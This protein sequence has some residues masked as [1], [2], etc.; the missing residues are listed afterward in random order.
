[1]AAQV[2]TAVAIRAS[3]TISRLAAS[4]SLR[5]AMNSPRSGPI[6]AR[7]RTIRVGVG[8]R[9]SL[10][11]ELTPVSLWH[12]ARRR[13]CAAS[14]TTARPHLHR[15]SRT[16]NNRH[17]RTARPPNRVDALHAP[18]SRRRRRCADHAEMPHRPAPRAR[19]RSFTAAKGQMT[20]T[21]PPGASARRRRRQHHAAF[22][23]AGPARVAS[24]IMLA[25]GEGRAHRRPRYDMA[26]A[27]AALR[28]GTC[29]AGS[30]RSQSAEQQAA[31]Q[32]VRRRRGAASRKAFMSTPA[33][34][35][36]QMLG[37]RTAPGGKRRSSHTRE[38]R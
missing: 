17:L 23:T 29:I 8:A 2:G 5:P 36:R 4:S 16:E 18:R 31:M 10:A 12:P 28:I 19:R 1:M 35:V 11:A 26:A 14:A 21:C 25:F 9:R 24:R 27:A 33:K 7:T 30:A 13:G 38:G 6:R 15:C 34:S 20:G 32:V 37:A 3:R 22:P